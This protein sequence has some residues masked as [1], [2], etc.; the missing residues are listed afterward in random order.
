LAFEVG[1]VSNARGSGKKVV[2]LKILCILKERLQSFHSAGC[3]KTEFYGFSR[4]SV[5]S[6]L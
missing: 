6:R 2:G 4:K 1:S 5:E 3:V